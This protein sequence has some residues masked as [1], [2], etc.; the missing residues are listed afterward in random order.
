MTAQSSSYRDRLK[1]AMAE[2]AFFS[3]NGGQTRLAERIQCTPQ[4][5]N[6]ILNS[7]RAKELSAGPHSRACVVLGVEALWL[8]DGVGPKY[9]VEPKAGQGVSEPSSLLLPV[10][11]ETIDMAVSSAERALLLK[12][13]QLPR[14]PADAL[15]T[16]V[17]TMVRVPL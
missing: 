1:E 15:Q 2:S 13:R 10:A 7:G 14:Q 4:A 17:D 11:R 5:I 16:I 9:R 12:I 3:S 8:A 6:Q